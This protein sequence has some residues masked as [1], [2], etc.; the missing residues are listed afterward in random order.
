MVFAATVL[1]KSTNTIT[2]IINIFIVLELTT[3]NDQH[4]NNILN[5]Y[6]IISSHRF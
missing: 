6:D 4:A 3:V 5:I 2:T 1:N